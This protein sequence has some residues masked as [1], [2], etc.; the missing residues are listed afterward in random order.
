MAPPKTS[1]VKH[2]ATIITM[3][4]SLVKIILNIV[5]S[6]ANYVSYFLFIISDY[7]M[8]FGSSVLSI[9]FLE[10]ASFPMKVIGYLYI[11]IRTIL[12]V[13]GFYKLYQLI[14]TNQT[15]DL[16][17]KSNT[18]LCQGSI[19]NT[20]DKDKNPLC[21]TATY[22]GQNSISGLLATVE[23]N[24]DKVNTANEICKKQLLYWF[25]CLSMFAIPATISSI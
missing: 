12:L 10:G 2:D 25:I 13:Y 5:Y 3:I 19:P 6:I 15:R 21:Q 11:F 23:Y 9:S 17:S 14:F 24:Y 16:F 1:V 7:L 8:T 20:T 4:Y 18:S 22:T